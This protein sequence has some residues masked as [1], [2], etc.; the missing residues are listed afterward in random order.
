MFGLTP[1]G[2][3]H[4]AI[5]LV[6]V[7]SG[8]IALVRDRQISSRNLLGQIYIVTTILTCLTAFGIFA[9]GGFSRGHA[10]AVI[11][12]IVLGIAGLAERANVFGHWSAYV[13][14]VSYSATFLFHMIPAFTETAT[15]L[16]PSEPLASS[17]DVPGLQAATGLLL[18]AFLIGATL[19]VRRL[20]ASGQ[21]VGAA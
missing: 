16:P 5:S 9:H 21:H 2:I 3:V 17:P 4:T 11:T 15:R 8:A 19:Q 13:A 14:T 20:R 6:A 18:V 1:L 7:A 10:L 12:L